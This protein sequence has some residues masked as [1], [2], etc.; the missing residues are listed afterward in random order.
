MTQ[1]Q[2]SVSIVFQFDPVSLSEFSINSDEGCPPAKCTCFTD[3]ESSA[4]VPTER[5]A[6]REM[7]SVPVTSLSVSTEN[8]SEHRKDLQETLISTVEQS[9]DGLRLTVPS[10]PPI[11]NMT[12]D[13]GVA[14]THDMVWTSSLQVAGTRLATFDQSQ[15]A[16]LKAA[17]TDRIEHGL[18]EWKTSMQEGST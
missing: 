7:G 3:L 8:L 5:C 13:E 10:W 18:Q 12:E 1:H 2:Y 6:T 4:D 9:I 17:I 14:A 11:A 15:I 16:G